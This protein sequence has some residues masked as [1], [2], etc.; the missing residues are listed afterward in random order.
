MV[1]GACG[2]GD[3]SLFG[4]G[5]PAGSGGSKADASADGSAGTGGAGQGGGAQGGNGQGGGDQGGS[6]QGGGAQGGSGQGGTAGGGNCPFTDSTDHDGD[7]WSFAD[8]DCNDCDNQVNPGAFDGAGPV[9]K[10][11]LDDD[12]DGAPDN[13]VTACDGSIA[14]DDTD[15]MNGARAIGLCAKAEPNGAGPS[16]RWGVISAA[17]VKADGTP[18]M[19]ALSHGITNVFGSVNPPD[20]LSM[21]VLSS[22]TARTPTQAGFQSLDGAKMGTTSGAPAGFPKGS[23]LCPGVTPGSVYDPAALELKIRVPTNAQSFQWQS[24]FFSTE[25]PAW[26]CTQF[27]DVFVAI[28]D[29]KPGALADGNVAFDE[30]GN[31]IS[32]NTHFLRV[33]QAQAAGDGGT[34]SYPCPL[35]TSQLT[36]TGFDTGTHGATGWLQTQAP[37]A[38]GSVIT[39]RFAIWDSADDIMDSTVLIDKFTWVAAPGGPVTT[40][41]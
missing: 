23:T 6:G 11:G 18:G 36:G 17:Y 32:V 30:M 31:A 41:L 8:G 40:P 28:L 16:K 37:A 26:V 5:A 24:N 7:G 22:G 25:F 19:N 1:A 15:A 29:P 14:L 3:D 12:C 20:G 35:G 38:P 21:L 39:L 34:V 27:N 9:G 2:G 10:P 4:G 13:A 33:C